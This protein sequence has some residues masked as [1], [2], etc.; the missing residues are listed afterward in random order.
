[1]SDP[2]ETNATSNDTKNMTPEDKRK[3]LEDKKKLLEIYVFVSGLI[4]AS[5]QTTTAL[6]AVNLSA[7]ETIYK[8]TILITKAIIGTSNIAFFLFIFLLLIYYTK[9]F[10]EDLKFTT[11]LVTLL[12]IFFS[13]ILTNFVNLYIDLSLIKYFGLFILIFIAILSTLVQNSILQTEL[14][15]KLTETIIKINGLMP[16]TLKTASNKQLALKIRSQIEILWKFI[17]SAV[18]ISIIY[19]ITMTIILWKDKSLYDK[20]TV[21]LNNLQAFQ[22]VS[23]LTIA[24]AY[25][26]FFLMFMKR[27]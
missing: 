13:Y 9:T 15:K 2:S 1:M 10:D 8:S 18:M 27:L 16:K 14:D 6:I 17:I 26:F 23:L 4:V 21:D 19:Y 7:N 11:L 24:V 5:T 20:L 25:S 22:F 12:S 3:L